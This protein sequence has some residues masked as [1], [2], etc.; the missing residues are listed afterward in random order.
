MPHVFRL[1]FAFAIFSLLLLSS[2]VLADTQKDSPLN[3]PFHVEAG[4]R[5]KV[6][7]KK[8][9]RETVPSGEVKATPEITL[10]YDGEFSK[11]TAKGFQMSWTLRSMEAVGNKELTEA[12]QKVTNSMMHF[13]IEVETD[14]KGMPVGLINRKALVDRSIQGLM[15]ASTLGKEELEQ[16]MKRTREIM[17][18]MDERTAAVT[19]LKDAALPSLFQNTNLIVGSS[20]KTTSLL[21]NPL[22]GP[23]ILQQQEL[24]LKK[25]DKQ[26][27]M[28]Y[29]EYESKMDPESAEKSIRAVFDK[30]LAATKGGNNDKALTEPPNKMS[31][32]RTIQG[33]AEVSIATG[34]VRS[35]DFEEDLL[36]TTPEGTREKKESTVITIEPTGK[37]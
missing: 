23:P 4:E 35:L 29:F 20:S 13:P 30:I 15:D 34:W 7:V 36:M 5:F 27:K 33:G 19:Y 31:I 37:P 22:G 1:S 11:A 21:P 17:E 26:S 32:N 9:K 28:A 14:E 18:K 16:Q 25:I 6:T 2:F 24:I 3:I 12:L 8:I 10:V